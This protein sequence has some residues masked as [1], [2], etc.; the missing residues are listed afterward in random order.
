MFIAKVYLPRL[1]FHCPIHPLLVDLS[2]ELK[3]LSPS[4]K[5]V[6]LIEEP[7]ISLSRPIYFRKFQLNPFVE[8]ISKQMKSIHSFDISF[9]QTAVLNND[10]QT[11][12]FFTLEIG[13]GYNEVFL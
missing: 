11:R 6:E 3:L 7:H 8:Q 12:S 9:A 10:E 5:N 2:E 13:K 4:L 1:L